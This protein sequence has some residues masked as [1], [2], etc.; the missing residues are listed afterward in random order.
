MNSYKLIG[1]MYWEGDY[2]VLPTESGIF[3]LKNPYL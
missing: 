1:E 3:K 2:L